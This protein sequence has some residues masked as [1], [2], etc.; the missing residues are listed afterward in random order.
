MW[1]FVPVGVDNRQ[2]I[3]VDLLD[4][5][6]FSLEVVDELVDDV[7]DRRGWNPFSGVYASIYPDCSIFQKVIE[8][9]GYLFTG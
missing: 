2:E 4:T 9:M 5:L 6:G 8:I 7:G 3:P 1:I